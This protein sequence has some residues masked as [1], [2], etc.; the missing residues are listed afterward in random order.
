[1][2]K[3]I[4]LV[5]HQIIGSMKNLL[6]FFVF[7]LLFQTAFGQACGVYRIRYVGSFYSE[8]GTVTSVELPTTHYLS[9]VETS[10]GWSKDAFVESQTVAGKFELDIKSQLGTPFSDRETLI[11][12]YKSKSPTF[13]MRAWLYN[14]STEKQEIIL[15]INWDD[16][17]VSLLKHEGVGAF[18]EF[19]FKEIVV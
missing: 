10:R 16:I 9:G 5:N 15:E 4:T 6:T 19:R 3:I 13:Q 12:Y 2:T 17:E 8:K 14:G 11:A 7:T 1:M 18:F